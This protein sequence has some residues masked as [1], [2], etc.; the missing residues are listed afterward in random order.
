MDYELEESPNQEDNKQVL[1]WKWIHGNV[2]SFGKSTD[3]NA[4]DVL[5]A[6][7]CPRHLIARISG[8]ERSEKPN[9]N[10]HYN[11]LMQVENKS[12]KIFLKLP[13]GKREVL[14]SSLC[15]SPYSESGI[16]PSHFPSTVYYCVAYS[17]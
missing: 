12:L 7:Y 13:Q 11:L 10:K 2:V 17:A 6:T 4:V 5:P 15:Q 16:Q 1:L 8:T 3:E 9:F 14:A